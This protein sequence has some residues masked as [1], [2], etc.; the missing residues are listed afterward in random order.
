MFESI[1]DYKYYILNYLDQYDYYYYLSP[2]FILVYWLYYRKYRNY[3][4]QQYNDIKNSSRPRG[5]CPPFFANGWFRLLNSDELKVNEVKHIDYCG[6]DVVIFRGT[7]GKVYAL[8]AF[9]AHM[10]ANLG[11]GGKIK[12]N[13]LVQCPFHGWLFDGET[14]NCVVSET[15]IKKHVEK[16]EYNDL[17]KMN[18]ADGAYLKKCYEGDVKLKKYHVRERHNSIMIWYDS[19]DEYQDKILFEPFEFDHDLEY[20]GESI[21]YVNCHMQEIPEKYIIIIFKLQIYLPNNLI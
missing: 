9:C 5:K 16:F 2:I 15:L 4:F 14:G 18:E 1:N 7:N 11:K 17:N 3:I 8:H 10:G 12:H 20:R 21:N 19:R 13:Q 6:R